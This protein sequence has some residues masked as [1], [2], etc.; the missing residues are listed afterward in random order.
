MPKPTLHLPSTRQLRYF[1]ALAELGHFGRAAASCHVS[2]S[3]FSVAIRELEQLLG[4][5]L[6]DRTNRQVTI[7]ATGQEVAVL[8]RLCLRDLSAL[9]EAARG[10]GGT[11]EGP[12][13]LGVIPT[14]APFLLPRAL[15]AIRGEH[16]DLKLFLYEDMT[17]NL[18][19]D[20]M[21]GKLDLLLIAVPYP[22]SGVETMELFRDHFRLAA[23]E[24]TALVDPDHYRFNR[25]QT[26][27]VLLLQEGHCLR[28]HAVEAC[29]IRDTEKMSQFSASSLLTLIEMVD[30]DMGITF[31]PE[32]AKGSALLS[33]TQV[34]TYPM[35][36][37]NYRRIALAWRKGT[38][39]A[40]E[41][42]ELGRLFRDHRG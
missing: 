31:L 41:F 22:L 33:Q 16:P 28:D 17:G 11:L 5:Q 13:H 42:R 23:R 30:A 6:V 21:D 1:A 20:L 32:M 24:G 9:V 4:A 25:L 29:R 27:S 8:A 15:P 36:R 7:T 3:A 39:R 37:D 19:R 2:Q 12:L 40:G 34:R 26:G 14:I 10:A 18:Y 35:G 38:A